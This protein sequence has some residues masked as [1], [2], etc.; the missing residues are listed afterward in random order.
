MVGKLVLCLA[1]G[2]ASPA[3][4]DVVVV[5]GDT[6]NVDGEI[7]DLYGIRAPREVC[8]DGWP[9]VD[10]ATEV[11]RELV[12]DHRV[13][14]EPKARSRYSPTIAVCRADGLDLG[15]LMV[16]AGWAW[17]L[18]GDGSDYMRQETEARAARAGMH[19][20]DC[21]SPRGRDDRR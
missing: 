21:L 14:C 9:A 18:A 16:R 11:L 2:I 15:S 17:T 8:P 19:S 10:M 5:D 13:T 20:H 12:R 6:I 4:A 3:L 7:F 1:I